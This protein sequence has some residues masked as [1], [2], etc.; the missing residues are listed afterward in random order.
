MAD[1]L[2]KIRAR[3]DALDDRIVELLN[4][5]AALAQQTG[6]AKSGAINEYLV[7]PVNSAE[8]QFGVCRRHYPLLL[9]RCPS[10]PPNVTS[11]PNI[12]AFQDPQCSSRWLFVQF[13]M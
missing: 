10:P 13:E 7:I 12:F 1:Q 5:R 6:H 8:I 4:E 9:E 3:I 11:R 2:K